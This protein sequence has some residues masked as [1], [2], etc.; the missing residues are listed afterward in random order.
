MET[1]FGQPLRHEEYMKQQVTDFEATAQRIS[2]KIDLVNNP[3]HY[4][5]GDIECIDA[6]RSALGPEGFAAFCRGNI[7]KYNW[8]CDHK[9][10]VQDVE[11]AGWYLERLI[12]TMRTKPEHSKPPEEEELLK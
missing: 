7:I 2:D 1:T 11:K 4:T 12:D 10:G 8:R 3:P 6:I 5:H 9:A